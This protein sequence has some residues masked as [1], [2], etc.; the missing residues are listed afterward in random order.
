[1]LIKENIDAA[2]S[3]QPGAA[4]VSE[5]LT[6]RDNN[7][8]A[9]KIINNFIKLQSTVLKSDMLRIQTNPSLSGLV[10]YQDR[11]ANSIVRFED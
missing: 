10:R 4:S 9:I 2:N 5:I 3:Y 6:G 1:M 8:K 7:K 11:S